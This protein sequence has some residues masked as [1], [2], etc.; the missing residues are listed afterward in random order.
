M[1]FNPLEFGKRKDPNIIRIRFVFISETKTGINYAPGQS[2]KH[3]K[4]VRSLRMSLY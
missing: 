3:E 2:G 4:Y 1:F